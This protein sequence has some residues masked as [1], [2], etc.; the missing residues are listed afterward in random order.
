MLHLFFIPEKGAKLKL[1]IFD[2]AKLRGG[3]YWK[4]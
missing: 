2:R 4:G 1:G 3:L